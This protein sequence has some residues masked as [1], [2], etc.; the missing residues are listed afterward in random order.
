MS[1]HC[2]AGRF[3]HHALNKSLPACRL[4][5][6]AYAPR[7]GRNLAHSAQVYVFALL[8][9]SFL[10]S[11]L[12]QELAKRGIQELAKRGIGHSQAFYPRL[13]TKLLV[14][15]ALIR[16]FLFFPRKPEE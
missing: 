7:I 15:Q 3:W 1:L 4:W 14:C 2:L 12:E 6:Q 13:S 9:E 11:R 10:A 16:F 8:G 5:G